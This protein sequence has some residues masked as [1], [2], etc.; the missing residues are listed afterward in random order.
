MLQD[1]VK[2]M[3]YV[4]FSPAFLYIDVGAGSMLLQASLAS[5]L[6]LLFL[7]QL[8]TLHKV[9]YARQK[10]FKT[11]NNSTEPLLTHPPG[12]LAAGFCA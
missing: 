1:M 4:S 11:M 9:F 8:K 2:G 5:L 7:R 12:I 10:T 3:L 6:Q